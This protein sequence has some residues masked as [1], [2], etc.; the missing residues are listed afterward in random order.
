MHFINEYITLLQVVVRIFDLKNKFES[1]TYHYSLDD[2]SFPS[3]G[4]DPLEPPQLLE[5]S[6]LTQLSRN[7]HP[8]IM[9]LISSFKANTIEQHEL[10]AQK[11]NPD[12]P[13][14][15][16]TTAPVADFMILQSPKVHLTEYLNT[17]KRSGNLVSR[18]ST[19][20]SE[21]MILSTLA[22]VLL[23]VGHLINNQIAHCAI[24]SNNI[25]VDE[26][27]YNTIL[28]S[29]FSHAI[30][31]NSQ[32]TNL[33]R[34]RQTQSRLLADLNGSPSRR[35]CVFSP[36]VMEAIE[37]SELENAFL[38]GE[39]KKIFAKNDT[40]SAA[41]MVYCWALSK[42]H[43]FLNQEQTKSYSYEDIPELIDFSPQC[44][45][46]LKRL[47]AYNH[48]DRLSPMEGAMA[49]FVLIFGPVA[50]DMRTED[51][52]YEWLLAETV[53]F[54]M[55]PVLI[56]SKVRDYTDSFS[57]L[58]CMYLTVASSNPKGVWEA[59]S[60]FNNYC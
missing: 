52:C 27:D 18:S 43:S 34:I 30:Q 60:F 3:F 55:R 2:V 33:E 6:L 35:H 24:S 11:L 59:C 7:Q 37:N 40:Y 4:T 50:S 9:E 12:N 58:L 20:T 10:F 41:W 42:S 8:N 47:I 51:Q 56:D 32:K 45:H 36:E 31:L 53:E 46:L 5:V 23:A 48:R 26:S 13:K 14:K 17:L 28:L 38:H 21:K 49:C 15:M 54:Y 57:K 16:Y 39:L 19:V 44:N 1:S 29:N 22:Q 25:Y